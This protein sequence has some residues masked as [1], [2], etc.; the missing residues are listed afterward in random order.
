[1]GGGG[2]FEVN[3]LKLHNIAVSELVHKTKT[4]RIKLKCTPSKTA[5][6]FVLITLPT[7]WKSR[8]NNNINNTTTITKHIAHSQNAIK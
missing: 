4:N 8:L 3:K 2:G 6:I 5:N 1:M 7:E